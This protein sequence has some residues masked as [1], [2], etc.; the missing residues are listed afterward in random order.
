MKTQ[1]INFFT[2]KFLL[3]PKKA[4][5]HARGNNR[6]CENIETHDKNAYI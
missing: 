5:K 3:G 4:A 2:K 6:S 1:N